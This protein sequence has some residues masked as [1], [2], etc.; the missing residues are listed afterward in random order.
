MEPNSGLA[1]VSPEEFQKL[2]RL[3]GKTS[4]AE[5]G[6]RKSAPLID[7]K[8]I[9][10][11]DRI[12][13]MVISGATLDRD[14]DTISLEGWDTKNWTRNP[15]VLFAHD[16]WQPPVARGI[17]VRAE[18]GWLKSQAEFT[19]QELYPFGYMIF[20]FYAQGYMKASSVGFKPKEWS[21]AEDRKFGVNFMRQELLEWSCVPV[22][23]NPDAL[24]EARS[25]GIDLTP[26]RQRYEQAFDSQL[27]RER[28]FFGRAKT[29]LEAVYKAVWPMAKSIVVPPIHQEAPVAEKTGAALSAAT[30]AAVQKA[31]DHMTNVKNAAELAIT[32][33]TAMIADAKDE[34]GD[35]G[36]AGRV[37]SQ[38]S[39]DKLLEI[40]GHADESQ[41]A[42]GSCIEHI[43]GMLP[44]A[45]DDEKNVERHT[46]LAVK[47]ADAVI[48]NDT[49]QIALIESAI[50]ALPPLKAVEQPG[51][52]AVK[53][54][55]DDGDMEID[56]DA[57]EDDTL[58]P[59]IE[60][61]AAVLDAAFAG[62]I[63]THADAAIRAAQGKLD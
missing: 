16:G 50:K 12:I 4:D 28:D 36:K 46:Q 27:H 9:S 58:D 51:P 18:G 8:V 61:T 3:A 24:V 52:A 23:S 6:I 63:K 41:K 39:V 40:S 38:A 56:L 5:V 49:A 42:A 48:A 20:Q 37:L 2:A 47:L 1:W 10:E 55:T 32:K 26:E 33:G 13:D 45:D 30:K 19:P 22:P 14:D 44:K 57:I 15:V 43:K 34:D 17:N 11:K 25:K 7:V 59:D 29:E 35:E 60:L 31:V 62:A 21:F 53:R 54:I